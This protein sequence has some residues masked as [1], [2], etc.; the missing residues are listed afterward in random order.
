LTDFLA[1]GWM[2]MDVWSGAFQPNPAKSFFAITPAEEVVAQD[3][4]HFRV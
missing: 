3:Q 2:M 4:S 1:F